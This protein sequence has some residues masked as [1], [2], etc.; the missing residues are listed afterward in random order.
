MTGTGNGQRPPP[1]PVRPRP[2]QGE[3]ADSYLRRLAAANHLRFSYLRR[4]L[5][6]PRGSYGPIDAAELAV[7]AGRKPHAILRAFPELGPAAL[8]Q[9][10]TGR[11]YTRED[12]QHAYAAKQ[13]RYA[14]IRRDSDAGMS[15]RT[16]E[17]KHHVGR[18]TI[19]KALDSPDPPA[20]KKIHREPAALNG[21]HP[22]IDAMIDADPA[23]ATATIWQRLADDHST[24]VAYPTLR[25]YV[26]SRR[27]AQA[28][29]KID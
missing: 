11:R 15:E 1:L 6:T 2:R 20:R 5:A 12:I 29:D 8:R 18:R 26:V 3:T 23:I 7:L 27:A 21:L 14:V 22:Q 25:A 13:Q 28:P 4:Y 17:R 10:G 24:T 16:I 19:I 9:T